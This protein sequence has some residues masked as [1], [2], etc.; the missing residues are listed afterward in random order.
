[1]TPRTET[2]R[3]FAIGRGLFDFI[4]TG[5]RVPRLATRALDERQ[6]AGRAFAAELLTPAEAIAR[7]LPADRLL[8]AE[9]LEELAAA[10][11]VS[12]EVIRHQVEKHGLARI[13]D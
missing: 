8:E 2:G 10:F 12:T 7:K 9:D 4:V 13:A 1:M 5:A 6:R 11:R 3:R